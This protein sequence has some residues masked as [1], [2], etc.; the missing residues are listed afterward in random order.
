MRL[1]SNYPRGGKRHAPTRF[2]IGNFNTIEIGI[3][4][5]ALR[6]VLNPPF[7][8]LAVYRFIDLLLRFMH[9]FCRLFA[10]ADDVERGPGE[11]RG[12]GIQI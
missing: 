2:R 7:C 1:F 5:P 9:G 8:N 11:Q 12:N 6:V 4:A 3:G 10:A